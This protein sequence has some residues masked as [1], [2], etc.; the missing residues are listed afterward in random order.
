M[1]AGTRYNLHVGD[2]VQFGLCELLVRVASRAQGAVTP[3][4]SVSP[5]AL[6]T[7]ISEGCI[8]IFNV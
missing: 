2:T 7:A 8:S 1:K 6:P 4:G 3:T 5:R